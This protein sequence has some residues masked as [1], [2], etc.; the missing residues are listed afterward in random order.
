MAGIFLSYRRADSAG[1]TGRLYDFLCH[2]FGEDQ[3]FMDVDNIRPGQDFVQA[4]DHALRRTSVVLVIIGSQWANIKGDDGQPRLWDIHDF[5]RQEV[6][7]ALKRG[8]MLIPVLLETT[9]MPSTDQLPQALH[10]LTRR[11]AI[12]VSN[13]RF[14]TDAEKLVSAIEVGTNIKPKKREAETQQLSVVQAFT[15]AIQ[16]EANNA[17]RDVARRFGF[18]MEDL[19]YNRQR[20]Y[21]PNQ[22]GSLGRIIRRIWRIFLALFPNIV[23]GGI[24][25]TYYYV[26]QL[27]Y[28][29][30]FN[31][32]IYA[33]T[34]NDGGYMIPVF[35][36]LGIPYIVWS[37]IGLPVVLQCLFSWGIQTKTGRMAFHGKYFKEPS[38]DRYWVRI[39][40][41]KIALSKEV[42]LSNYQNDYSYVVRAYYSA[43]VG[44]LS[45]EVVE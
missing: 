6:E 26:W 35:A 15:P 38:I 10:D 11:N 41:K 29:G 16:A 23:F 4:L 1:Y 17:T 18:T 5:V 12:S 13:A 9:V 34:N 22:S 25:F 40:G 2:Y 21:S 44:L 45:L 24:F 31:D 7:Q 39:G 32:Y 36:C 28:G 8:K 33:F 42:F 37:L 30:T 20:Q 14:R 43:S 27:D 19:A 3:V